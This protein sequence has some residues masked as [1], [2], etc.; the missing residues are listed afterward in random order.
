MR[1]SFKPKTDQYHLYGDEVARPIKNFHKKGF[2]KRWGR[3]K[4]FRNIMK[5]I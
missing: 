2:W 4:Y 1:V 5:L 3:K